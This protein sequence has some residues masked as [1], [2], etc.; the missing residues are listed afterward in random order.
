MPQLSPLVHVGQVVHD[1]RATVADLQ[2]RY[3]LE[4]SR[5]AM[6]LTLENGWVAVQC[7]SVNARYHFLSLGNTE[8]EVIEPLGEDSP[9]ARFLAEKGEGLH[10]LCFIVNSIDE[11]LAAM[12][13]AELVVDAEYRPGA[14]MV[15]LDGTAHGVLMELVQ[16]PAGF[17]V[18]TALKGSTTGPG[19]ES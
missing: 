9:Y 7:Q 6:E 8:L 19:K 14:R 13:G 18:S 17:D 11:H 15:Y 2:E 1:A 4:E 10:H 16:L 12:P 5:P 3:G